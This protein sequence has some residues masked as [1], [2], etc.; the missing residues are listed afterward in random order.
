MQNS[1]FGLAII[2]CGR[3]GLNHVRTATKLFGASFKLACDIDERKREKVKEI[4]PDVKFVTETCDV[5]ESSE[6][7][8]VVVATPVSTHF[9]L[10]KKFLERDK[11]VLVEKPIAL[12]LRDAKE[13]ERLAQERKRILMVGHVL[14]YH[15]AIR[16]IK[17]LIQNGTLGRLQYI[18]SN[19]LNLGKV[20]KEENILWSFAPHDISI[21]QYLIEEDPIE[22]EASGAVFLQPGIHDVTT[23][24]LVYP[25]NIHAH[26][27]V[28][29][30]YPFK[31][32]RLIV[33]GDKS[34]VSFEDSGTD[35]KLILYPKGI[36]WINGEP[37]NRDGGYRLIDYEDGE[38]LELEL[39]HFMECVTNGVEPIT[40]GKSA[41]KVLEILE[42]AQAQ[43][44]RKEIK[45]GRVPIG[46]EIGQNGKFFVHETSVVDEACEIGE[47]TKIWHFS[48]VQKGATIGKNCTLGQNVNVGNNVRIGNFVKIQNNVSIYEGVTLE[49]YVFCGP[50]MVFTNIVDPRSKYPQ[51]GSKYYIK[52]LV[53]EGASLGANS[54]IVCGHTIGRYAFVG[55]GAV[56]TKDIPDYALAL[57]NPARIVGWMSEAGKRLNFD[58]DGF[59]SCDKSRKR[60]KL[61]SGLVKEVA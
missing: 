4:C 36:D 23:T 41:A 47:G 26:I 9:T 56:V 51:V 6:I 38:P 30:L 27:H 45:N 3:W 14:I 19:R 42:Q 55:A 46:S 24:E 10:A 21:L 28:S 8:S 50:S 61:E 49:D 18:C 16:K 15:P 54:T 33:I 12:T 60:Y 32:H 57:G 40:D 11:H 52:T 59:A 20:R 31:E 2:G 22:I 53:K 25:K 5:L 7:N 39:K 13:L 43:L 34:M 44:E 29:W 35:R 37:L 48:H 17:E 1:S 58:E